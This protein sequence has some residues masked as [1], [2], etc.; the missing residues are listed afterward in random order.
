MAQEKNPGFSQR[1]TFASLPR[2]ERGQ[3]IVMGTDPKGENMVYCHGNSVV[4]RSLDSPQYS[5]IYTQHSCQVNVA[6]YS[7]SR[8]YIASADKS[9][10]VR[11]W[12]TVNKEHIL[13]NEFQPIS[14][15]IKDL[16]W[17]GDN[18]RIVVVGEGREKFGHVFLADTGTS[19]GDITGQTRP[20]NTVDFKPSRPFRIVTGSEDNT[21]AVY[22]GPPFKFKGTK[23]EHTRY[24][25]VVRY[26]PDGNLWASGGFD[27]KI[28]LYDGKDSE[29]KGELAGHTGGV[30]G[31]AW[32]G[33]SKKLL[34]ASGD[35]T[36]KV[37]DV[38]NLCCLA[39]FKMGEGVEDQQVGCLWSG[40]HLVSVSLSGFLNFLDL[41]N[42]SKVRQVVKGHNKPITALALAT[43]KK[44]LYTGSSD[45]A[46]VA[47]DS[48]TG[49]NSRVEGAGHGVQIQ[50]LVQGPGTSF[51][52][53]GFDD[54]LRTF[55]SATGE[56]AGPA[57][58]LSAQPRALAQHADTTFVATMGS[59]V[60]L[61][62]GSV[63]QEVPVEFEPTCLAYSSK[64]QH[65]AV[66]DAA[67]NTV[68]IYSA[69]GGGLDL[70]TEVQLTGSAMDAAF[71]PDQKY[72]VTSDSNRKV[73]LLE[74]GGSYA[75]ATAKEWGFHTAKVNCVAW[76]PNSL[77]VASGGLD[78]SI[79][80]W[81][82]ENPD[83]H[84]VL[85]NAHE[86]S[87]ITGVAW[88]D[89]SSLVSTGQDSNTKLW[90]VTW[91]K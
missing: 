17:S 25:Q 29:P 70:V 44:T 53:I 58:S 47:W 39:T 20:I 38:A 57:V 78:T 33:A 64:L 16:A 56:F 15:P 11:I 76:A 54:T 48:E 50:G 62:A 35:K 6:K 85:R 34:S 26:S 66:G 43:N 84:C 71:S 51:H 27:G 82:V 18:Q 2:T 32:D 45:G 79:I 9:G 36:C 4:V 14:G 30:Y 59:L 5:D 65:L 75:K 41:D 49:R 89:N 60:V 81:S 52:T 40:P 3:P 77:Y 24:C 13:K 72:L 21:A 7:P 91:P 1:F 22:E 87:Q 55:D 12:D 83:K 86:Q 80:L 19:N 88:L 10:K 69:A 37:W 42:P 23:T 67:S 90:N 46:I 68:R 28:F 31:L 63:Q 61:E 74:A 73:T 8:F